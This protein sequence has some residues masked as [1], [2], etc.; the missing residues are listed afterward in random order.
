MPVNNQ[1]LLSAS[2]PQQ[3]CAKL[4]HDGGGDALF[5]DQERRLAAVGECDAAEPRSE[6]RPRRSRR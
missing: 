3:V 5:E 2:M 4:D 1:N 6:L